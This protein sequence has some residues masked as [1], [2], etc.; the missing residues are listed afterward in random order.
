[1]PT[2]IKVQG[3]LVPTQ[4][5]PI[6]KKT[7]FEKTKTYHTSFSS[8]NHGDFKYVTGLTVDVSAGLGR[9]I[10]SQMGNSQLSKFWADPY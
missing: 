2:Q 4:N 1:M 5:L 8:L 9:Q 3:C 10:S 7:K 6:N